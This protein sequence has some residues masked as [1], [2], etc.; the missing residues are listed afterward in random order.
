MR[1][2]SDFIYIITIFPLFIRCASCFSAELNAGRQI[3]VSSQEASWNT[4]ISG[5]A[6]CAPVQTSYGFAV[7]T[8]GRMISACTDT[9]TVLWK[10]AVPGRPDP[11]LTV[12]DDDF[13]LTVNDGQTLSLTNPGGFTLW[14]ADVSFPVISAPVQG[15]DGRIFVRGEK[16][17]SCYSIKGICKWHISTE[18][19]SMLPAGELPDGSLVVF[20][21][22]PAGGKT[23]AVRVSPFGDV[24]EQITFTGIVT[25]AASCG[26]GLLLTFAGGGAGLCS[27]QDAEVRSVWAVASDDSIFA[28]TAKDDKSFFLPAGTS[29][30][31]LVQPLSGNAKITLFDTG[32]GSVSAA[33]TIPN[34]NM[35]RPAYTASY[36]NGI[37]LAD[38][39]H[40]A[41]VSVDG[42]CEWSAVLPQ[43]SSSGES[44]NYLTYTSSGFLVFC[45]TS[46]AV[47]GYRVAQDMQTRSNS[48]GK[49][50]LTDYSSF[51]KSEGTDSTPF[52]VRAITGEI[53]SGLTGDDRRGALIQGM[54]GRKEITW[55]QEL[56]DAG[57]AYLSYLR[58][59]GSGG[60]PAPSVFN[61]D[62]TGTD[63]MLRQLSLYGTSTFPPLIAQLLNSEKNSAHMRT[64]L[65]TAADCAY[66]PDGSLLDALDRALF[67]IPVQDAALQLS[68]CDAVYSV[69]RFM[70]R[71]AFYRHGRDILSNLLS[72][73]YDSRVRTYAR[74]TLT[75][76]ADLEL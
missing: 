76:I 45:R 30:A 54:Y 46:W 58:S 40:A 50:V 11:F 1:K 29:R 26:D 41:F 10:R 17:I 55:T 73:Q 51:I 2:L 21:M 49:K 36:E 6:V 62:M 42:I 3:A 67:S 18:Q 70:G 5:E 27:I 35:S 28:G 47:S 32:S 12:L 57:R 9:G 61:S 66:D 38:D 14:S 74:R 48:G 60:R 69:C 65:E 52:D 8:D 13:L 43:K 33:L 63:R 64:L 22:Q 44:W 19:Q 23:A 34:I 24:L 71:P 75:R 4:V 39:R 15:R 7:L 56:L 37:L 59:S 16:D 31:A 53:G 20:L 25:S 72:P 68:L